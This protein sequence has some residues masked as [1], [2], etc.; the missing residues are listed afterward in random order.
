MCVCAFLINKKRKT[1]V[2]FHTVSRG[3]PGSL[4][5]FLQSSY[6]LLEI[7][8]VQRVPGVLRK[9]LEGQGRLEKVEDSLRKVG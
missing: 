4:G 9:S 5:P 1:G 2:P 8:R 6:I 3:S 7:E